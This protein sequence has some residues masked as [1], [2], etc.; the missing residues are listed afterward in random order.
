MGYEKPEML[1]LASAIHAIQQS[2]P[3]G[4]GDSHTDCAGNQN[5]PA[6]YEADE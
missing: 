2:D 3:C 4:K 1:A 5:T 6:A